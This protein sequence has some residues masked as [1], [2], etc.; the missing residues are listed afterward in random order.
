MQMN[1]KKKILIFSLA[2]YPSFISGAEMAVKE[3]T[4]R[5]K[6]TEIEFHLLTA[7][8]DSKAPTTEKIGTVT[9]HR[10]GFGGTY[11]SKILFIPLAAFRARSLDKSHHFDGL[12]AIMTYMLLP[13][14]LAKLLGLNRPYALTL[15]DLSLIHI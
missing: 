11:L 4:D 7:R 13:V 5:I 8:F 9:V 6:P 1:P 2:Y 3:I 14:V 15:Q 12:W 10:V